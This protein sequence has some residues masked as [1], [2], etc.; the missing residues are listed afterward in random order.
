MSQQPYD[1]SEKLFPSTYVISETHVIS[2]A[3]FYILLV[4]PSKFEYIR[5]NVGMSNNTRKESIMFKCKF[6]PIMI[7]SSDSDR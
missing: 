7:G 1:I 4:I 3:I 6:I 2:E 5:L